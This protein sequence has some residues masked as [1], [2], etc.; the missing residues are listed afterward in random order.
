[1]NSKSVRSRLKDELMNSENEIIE[2]W[3]KVDER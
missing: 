1:M 3:G 2:F